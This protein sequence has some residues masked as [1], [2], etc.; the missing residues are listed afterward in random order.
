ML[1]QNS[2]DV[3][4]TDKTMSEALAE[5]QQYALGMYVRYGEKAT[6]QI[7]NLLLK[8]AQNLEKMHAVHRGM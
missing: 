8:N 6:G 4:M 3:E 2:E 7:G 1:E 5:L